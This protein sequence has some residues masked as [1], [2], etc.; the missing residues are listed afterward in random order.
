M[1]VE[2]QQI[3]LAEEGIIAMERSEKIAFSA[4]FAILQTVANA[5]NG[6]ADRLNCAEA[7][8]S[9]EPLPFIVDAKHNSAAIAKMLQDCVSSNDLLSNVQLHNAVESIS[10]CETIEGIPVDLVAHLLP[11]FVDWLIPGSP[12]MKIAFTLLHEVT[13]IHGAALLPM[14]SQR[15]EWRRVVAALDNVID[16]IRD[17]NTGWDVDGQCIQTLSQFVQ[18]EAHL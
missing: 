17:D 9:L 12:R 2:L 1:S 16:I 13:R 10:D 8:I 7:R 6:L 14:P 3:A 11:L 5:L 15:R 18:R 4:E